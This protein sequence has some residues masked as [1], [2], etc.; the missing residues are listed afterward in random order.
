MLLLIVI[1]CFLLYRMVLSLNFDVATQTWQMGPDAPGAGWAAGFW[2]FGLA[3]LWP[4]VALTAKRLHDIGAHGI[5]ALALF[6]PALNV[7]AFL[8]LC[9]L[10]GTSGANHYGPHTNAGG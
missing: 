3:S 1:Q 5:Y 7:V 6:V 9:M 8:V 4:T 10:P 2:L